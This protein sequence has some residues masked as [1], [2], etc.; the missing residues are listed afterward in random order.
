MSKDPVGAQKRFVDKYGFPFPMLCDESGET[1][2]AY[3]AWGEK[4]FM[5]KKY[6]GVFRIAYLIGTDGHIEQVYGKVKVGKFAKDVL[7]GLG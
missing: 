7:G 1:L 6:K 4:S 3:E 5:G 2:R